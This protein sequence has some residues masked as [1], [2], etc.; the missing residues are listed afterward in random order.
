MAEEQKERVA[1]SNE[2]LEEAVLKVLCEELDVTTDKAVPKA[3]I[4]DNL[5]ADSL[6]LAEIMM[7]IEDDIGVE[8]SDD[9]AAKIETVQD[10]IVQVKLAVRSGKSKIFI[11][12]N[13]AAEA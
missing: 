2:K 11:M 10:A 1:I 13:Q 7:Q 9:D 8:I 6:A 3:H 12:Q 4:V 5:G